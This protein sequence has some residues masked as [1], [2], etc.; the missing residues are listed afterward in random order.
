MGL[1][2]AQV[3]MVT[4]NVDRDTISRNAQVLTIAANVL[5]LRVGVKTCQVHVG[6]LYSLMSIPC[7]GDLGFKNIYDR[8]YFPPYGLPGI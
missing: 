3:T 2:P 4:A 6:A 1:V 5:G 7:P 8:S